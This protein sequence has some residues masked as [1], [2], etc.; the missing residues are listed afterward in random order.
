MQHSTPAA[1]AVRETLDRLLASQTFGRSERARELLRYLVE[2]EQA[3]EADKLKGFSI[4]VDVFGKDA[5][6]DPSTDAV[7]RVQA[8]RLRELLDQYFS[9]EGAG[10]PIR[11]VI[12]RGSYIP[13]YE[14]NGV[15]IPSRQQPIEQQVPAVLEQVPATA[16]AKPVSASDAQ[17]LSGTTV[18]LF[19]HLHAFWIAIALFFIIMITL[20]VLMLRQ[21]YGPEVV[22][23]T[24][25]NGG[26]AIGNSMAATLEK[27]P[28]VYLVLVEKTPQTQRIETM[29][30]AGLSNM[31][32]IQFIDRKPGEDEARANNPTTFAFNLGS[33]ATLGSVTIEV[34][35]LKTGRVLNSETLSA[36]ETTASQ[37]S[38]HVAKILGDVTGPFGSIYGYIEQNRL[39]NDLTTCV[40]LS[41]TYPSD[42]SAKNHEAAYR[43]LE[44]L[45][46][47]GEASAMIYAQLAGQQLD[48]IVWGYPYPPD[49]SVQQAMA[50]VNKAI[51]IDPTSSRAYRMAAYAEGVVGNQKE[52]VRWA[53]KALDAA[54]Y[55]LRTVYHYGWALVMAGN[56]QEGTALLAR[57]L[58]LA[59]PHSKWLDYALFQGAFMEGDQ[60]LQ[61]RAAL[62]LSAVEPQPEYLAAQLIVA[63]NSRDNTEAARILTEIN[64]KFPEF[65]ASPRAMFLKNHYPPD[66]TE[67]L[68]QALSAA[69]LPRTAPAGTEPLQAPPAVALPGSED[70]PTVYLT[71]KGTGSAVERVV[72]ALRAGLTH[73]ETI[74]FVGREPAPDRNKAADGTS[75]VFNVQSGPTTGSVAVEVQNLRS[76]TV[77]LSRN[78]AAFD[79]T[80]SQV[81]PQVGKILGD[82]APVS[83]AI[84]TFLARN[85]LAK[86]LV[87]CLI[88]ENA[89]ELAANAK[90]H[91]SA[92]RCFEALANSDAKSSIVYSSLSTLTTTGLIWRY[93]Y[94][95]NASLEKAGEFAQRAIQADPSSPRAYNAKAYISNRLGIWADTVQWTSKAYEINPYDPQA[96]A[97]YAYALTFSGD[98]AKGMAVMTQ[99]IEAAN[100]AHAAWWDYGLFASAYMQGDKELAARAVAPLASVAPNPLF[101]TGRLIVASEGGNPGLVKDIVDQLEANFP[102]FMADPRATLTKR[103]YPPD[104]VEKFIGALR[105]AGVSGAT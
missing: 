25:S 28:A 62:A 86:G 74:N 40:I 63:V 22:S 16:S 70:L 30:R 42:Q 52:R 48:A 21:T 80:T 76:D 56:Y 45:V 78:L 67:K 15:R 60:E 57:S 75:F 81:G 102:T 65:A 11:I 104:M 36:F 41:K 92:Y 90:I 93:A 91:E 13:S 97:S 103:N 32:T 85:G 9:G 105:T 2:R 100:G 47:H 10:E 55:D 20:M 95:L 23:G 54:P 73:F 99:A 18:I 59:N 72:T 39:Q 58:N 84:Y 29:L 71:V 68:L 14:P 24:K 87:D 4:A 61:K 27:L 3:G 33:G 69:G 53:K 37:A 44:D 64:D 19:K 1:P 82:T 8:G 31:E 89:F 35:N 46:A 5:G 79:A 88:Q 17:D 43:C 83:G 38:D 66:L 6:F 26:S 34:K 96:I 7:V 51:Q 50:L 101:L 98:Y 49:P 94:P 12:P 77:V